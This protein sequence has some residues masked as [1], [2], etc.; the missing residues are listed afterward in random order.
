MA[1][2]RVFVTGAATGIGRALCTA[3][4]QRGGF[5]SGTFWGPDDAQRERELELESLGGRAMFADVDVRNPSDLR[6]FAGKAVEA[7]GGLDLWVNNA[8]M[9]LSRP[10][11]ETTEAEWMEVLDTNLLGYVRGCRIAADLLEA[12]GCIVNVSSITSMQPPANLSAYSTAKGGVDSLT[13][14]LAVE[15][16]PLGI[17]VNGVA[18]GAIDTALNIETWSDEARSIYES[19]APLGRLG[20]P[21]DIAGAILLL[22]GPDAAFVTGEVLVADGGFMINGTVGH[23]VT[24]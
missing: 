21:E 1:G 10:F 3:V 6:A 11:L 24:S 16:A 17:R 14:S 9:M 2:P 13:R 23:R 22:A 12:G 8:V 15:L 20:H 18:P 19:R 7:M 5:V 4:A